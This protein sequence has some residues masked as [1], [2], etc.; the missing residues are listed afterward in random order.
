M[1]LNDDLIKFSKGFTKSTYLELGHQSTERLS[2]LKEH[3]SNLYGVDEDSENFINVSRELGTTKNVT[4]LCGKSFRVPI[5]KYDVIVNNCS[6]IR[7]GT[8]AC[9]MKNISTSVFLLVFPNPL[10]EDL[11][12]KYFSDITV[13]ISEGA[14]AVA[15][16]PEKRKELLAQFNKEGI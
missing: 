7:Q 1:S 5:N 11:C 3:F 2:A 6:D 13:S 4:L 15:V 14:I 9:L 12:K 10:A 16:T 8:I